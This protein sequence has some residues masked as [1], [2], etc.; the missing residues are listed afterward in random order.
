[1]ADIKERIKQASSRNTSLL[2]TLS[3]TDYAGPALEQQRQFLGELKAELQRSNAKLKTLNNKRIVEQSEHKRYRD[4]HVKRFMYRAT[5]QSAKFTEKASK[6]EREYY[7][8]L[9]DIQE[10]TA[11][12]GNL[13]IQIADAEK[14]LRTLEADADTHNKA[15]QDLDSLYTSIFSGPTPQFPGEDEKEHRASSAVQQY[16]DTRQKSE[17]E[18][19]AIGLL[20]EASKHLERARGQVEAALSYSRMDMFGGGAAADIAERDA[21]SQA[22]Y[23]VHQA[24][25]AVVRASRSSPYVKELPSINFAKGS[26][27]SDVVFDNI[28]TDYEFHQKLKASAEELLRVVNA[29][30]SQ[31][32]ETRQRVDSLARELQ[33]RETELRESRFDLQKFRENAFAQVAG[34]DEGAFGGAYRGYK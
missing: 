16:N 2:D 5:G 7:E 31:I 8:V 23:S 33:Q 1:M 28:F 26:I 20:Y 29:L 21:V 19:Y 14:A 18:N 10:E 27:I 25:M 17:A 11:I 9:Q 30:N 6:E 13:E 32:N 34:G 22:E 4:S 3:R 24:Q 12:N 15:Q